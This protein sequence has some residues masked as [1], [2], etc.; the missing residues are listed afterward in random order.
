MKLSTST[1]RYYVSLLLFFLSILF[2]TSVKAEILGGIVRGKGGA[3]K[4]Y[5]RVEVYGPK[6]VVVITD[7]NG[8][9]SV[10]VPR[11]NYA[12]HIIERNRVM[13]FTAQAPGRQEF[14]VQ[15]R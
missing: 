4:Q 1:L 15:W 13:K 9:F 10:D 7:Q 8:G 5:V 6:N 12:V 3:P 11:G 2:V 14:I